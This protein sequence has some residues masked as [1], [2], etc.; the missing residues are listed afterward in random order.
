MEYS[1]VIRTLGKA[2][3]RYQQTLDSLV[4]QT[5]KPKAIIVYIAEGFPIPKETVGLERYVYVKKGMVA[6]RALAYEEVETEYCLFLDDDVYLPP[7]AVEK[8]YNEMTEHQAQVISPNVFN[9]HL[10]PLKKKIILTLVGRK[11]CRL[12]GQRWGFKMLP[13][14]G[15]SYPNRPTKPV[16]E[17]QVN[18][19]PCFFCKKEDFLKTHF[20]EELWLDQVYYAF[21]EDYV[22]FYKMYLLGLKQLTTYDTG[23]VHL[24]ASTTVCLEEKT[25]KIVYAEY[26]NKIILWHRLIYLPQRNPLR[27]MWSALAFSYTLGIQVVKYRLIALMGRKAVPQCFKEGIKDGLAYIKSEEYLNLPKVKSVR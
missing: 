6:Q 18:A 17:S 19:G 21:P 25:K 1:A 4:C 27:K 9:S 13:N 22:M 15:T 5:I 23:I 12:F 11:I 2:G 7:D 8:L 14:A 10:D 3:D 16:Y 20:E 26:R 24:D